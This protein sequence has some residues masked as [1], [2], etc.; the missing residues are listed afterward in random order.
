MSRRGSKR[1]SA[2]APTLPSSA[3]G[4]SSVPAATAVSSSSSSSSAVRQPATKK[5]KSARLATVRNASNIPRSPNRL[6]RCIVWFKKTVSWDNTPSKLVCLVT[7]FTA[8]SIA[9]AFDRVGPFVYRSALQRTLVFHGRD[10]ST[11]NE[12]HV[13]IADENES[14]QIGSLPGQALLLTASVED[15]VIP[16]GDGGGGW[17]CK[18]LSIVEATASEKEKYSYGFI[19]VAEAT[20]KGKPEWWEWNSRQYPKVR[21]SKV[22]SLTAAKEQLSLKS[23]AEIKKIQPSDISQM[24][25]QLVAKW[26]TNNLAKNNSIEEED[27]DGGEEGGAAGEEAT[28]DDEDDAAAD[29]SSTSS[30]SDEEEAV[31][32]KELTASQ[33]QGSKK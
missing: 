4:S 3:Y 19:D 28:I 18:L 21:L 25:L 9:K 32:R 33:I 22:K 7:E 30:D 10:D 15:Y 27:Y 16:G 23:P 20:N 17:T 5:H 6:L 31:V 2:P 13:K 12:L 24:H 11:A 8:D 26:R 1:V 29:N 14:L